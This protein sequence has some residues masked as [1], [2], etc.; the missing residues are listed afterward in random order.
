M[1]LM[2]RIIFILLF[3]STCYAV[4]KASEQRLDEVTR[5]GMHVMPFDLEQTIHVFSKTA[6]GGEQAVIAKNSDN[7]EQIKLIREHLTKIFHEF[8][9]GDFSDPAKI[10]GDSMPGLDALRK[11]QPGQLMMLYKDV[12]NGA[13]ITYTTDDP[14][15]IV[16]IHQ[17]FDAQLSDHSRHSVAGHAMHKMH[18]Q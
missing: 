17:W 7:D 14:A 4:E 9:Q 5:R 1:S 13:R 11:A 12:P 18:H 2:L 8:Q 16:A 3:M 15:L 6:Q 10:H